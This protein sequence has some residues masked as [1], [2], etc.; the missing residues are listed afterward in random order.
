MKSLILFGSKYG[1]TETCANKLKGYMNGEVEVLNI[2][3]ASNVLLDDYDK[4]IIGSPVYA[5]MFNKGIKAF[6]ENNKSELMNKK[7]GLFMCCMSDGKKITEQ[8]EANVPKELLEKAKI[9]ESLGGE[10]KFSKMN[11]FEK[12][13]I[14]MISKKDKSL[15]EINGKTDISRIDE[16][17]IKNF[18]K[19]ME[20]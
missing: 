7:L 16:N 9:M 12:K 2:N 14:K 11:F 15:G 17:A 8:F 18:T 19:F 10:F 20:E 6:I 5:G 13:I 3:K 1:T 4:V